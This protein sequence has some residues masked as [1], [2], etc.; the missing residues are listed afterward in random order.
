MKRL[1]TVIGLVLALGL[2]SLIVSN[3]VEA[4]QKASYAIFFGGCPSVSLPVGY[5]FIFLGG[6]NCVG[7]P[8]PP[9]GNPMGVLIP[10]AGTLTNLH[11]T[12]FSGTYTVYVNNSSTS[13]SCTLPSS[14]STPYPECFNDTD[15]VNVDENDIVYLVGST[16]S[17]ASFSFEKQ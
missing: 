17:S 15:E 4:R 1:F 11:I 14:Y 5:S 9:S 6:S 12:G 7:L 3:S 10:S 2:T 16:G 8:L 13:L